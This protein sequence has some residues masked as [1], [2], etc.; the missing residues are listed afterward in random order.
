M[1][2]ERN[3]RAA[4]E[5]ERVD[6]PASMPLEFVEQSGWLPMCDALH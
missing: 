5:E 4:T 2:T 6:A 3:S 1:L